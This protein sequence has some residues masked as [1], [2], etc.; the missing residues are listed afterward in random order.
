LRMDLSTTG[1][2]PA[3]ADASPPAPRAEAPVAEAAAASPTVL[4]PASDPTRPATPVPVATNT[5]AIALPTPTPLSTPMAEPPTDTFAPRGVTQ[6]VSGS[7]NARGQKDRYR[8]DGVQG[9]LLE[10]RVKRTSGISLQP[11]LEL[12][13]PN[14]RSEA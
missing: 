9:Q 2:T 7:I 6:S 12:L 4:A 8:F 11:E 10:A 5:P 3:A 14:G 13:D 1:P